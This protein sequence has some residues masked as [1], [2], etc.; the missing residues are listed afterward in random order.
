LKFQ[1]IFHVPQ[2]TRWSIPRAQAWYALQAWPLGANYIP[3]TAVNTLE[4][5]QEDT[6][7]VKTIQRELFWAHQRLRMN[8]LRVFLHILVWMDNRDKFF[9]RVDIFLESAHNNSLKVMPVL[10]DECWN[11]D[12][13]LGKQPDPIPGVH[14]SRWVR[15]PGQSMLLNRTSWPIISQ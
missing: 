3:S 2:R 14:N 9:Q 12:P 11:A 15:C 4:M 1:Y 13:Q 6:F 8:V 7:D 5:W 10:F